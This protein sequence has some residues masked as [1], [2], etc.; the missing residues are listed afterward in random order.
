MSD[1]LIYSK[2]YPLIDEKV[3]SMLDADKPPKMSSREKIERLNDETLQA[4]SD[5]ISLIPKRSEAEKELFIACSKELS[6]TYRI[7]VDIFETSLCLITHLYIPDCNISGGIK[8]MF[9]RLVF[10]SDDFSFIGEANKGS[11]LFAFCFNICDVYVNG[12]KL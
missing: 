8:K 1:K 5:K 10:L 6:D 9:Q 11:S 7:S 2:R 12:K 3:K 4:W